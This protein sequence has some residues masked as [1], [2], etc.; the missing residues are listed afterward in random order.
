VSTGAAPVV[1]VVDDDLSVREALHSLIRSVGLQVGTFARADEFLQRL[2]QAVP[3]PAC[4][5][6]DVRMP[7]MGGLELQRELAGWR[8]LLP[9]VF[10]TGHGDIPMTVRA[11][12]AGA[13]EFLPKPFREQD[14]LDAIRVALEQSGQAWREQA[15]QADIRARFET[16]SAREREV[17]A[18]LMQGLRNKQTADRLGISEVTVKV[19]RHN[20]M[21]KMK[22]ASLPALLAM[23]AALQPPPLGGRGIS[24]AE[25]Q[26]RGH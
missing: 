2:K 23:V 16:L 12:R 3:G 26:P 18:L 4:L 1:F 25:G 11:M 21:E 20:L 14:L 9:I 13:V 22:A 8:Q 19:H 7:G 6:L 10:I 5:V 17:L 15:A 24:D